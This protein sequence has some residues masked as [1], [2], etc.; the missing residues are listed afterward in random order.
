M[1]ASTKIITTVAGN[2]KQGYSGDNGPATSAESNNPVS[3][4]VDAA[5]NL[6]ISDE[7]NDRIREVAVGSGIITTVAGN[8]TAGYGG[9]GGPAISSEVN[10][11]QNIALD[12][13]G[14]FYTADSLYNRV[15]EVNW[16]ANQLNFAT[17]PIGFTSSDSPQ[18]AT[19]SRTSAMRRWF[20]PFLHLA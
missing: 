10:Q 5:G 12:S 4:A 19:V 18:T 14:N 2:H 16:L 15:R 3:I 17:T 6:Y 1:N 9:D 20:F 11:P 7:G 8:G 13:A